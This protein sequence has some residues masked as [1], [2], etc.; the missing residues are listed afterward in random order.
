VVLQICLKFLKEES[1]LK[2]L[3]TSKSPKGDLC[4]ITY[5][6]YLP[7]QGAGGYIEEWI[8]YSLFGVGSEIESLG[9]KSRD[10]GRAIHD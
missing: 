1:A 2:S 8:K 4:K 9:L 6:Q 10:P 3:F 5:Y 7:L